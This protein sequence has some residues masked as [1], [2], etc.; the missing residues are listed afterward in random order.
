MSGIKFGNFKLTGK[1]VRRKLNGHT[2]KILVPTRRVSYE[3][4]N[5]LVREFLRKKRV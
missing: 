2:V 1:I 5:R 4:G 3:E